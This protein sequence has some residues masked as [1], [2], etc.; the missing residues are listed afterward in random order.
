M[1]ST[2][3]GVNRFLLLVVGVLLLA[4][5]AA[6]IVLVAVP[7]IL[8]GWKQQADS[9]TGSAPDWVAAPAVGEVSVLTIVIGVVAVVL[10]LLLILFIVRHGQGH[11]SRVIDDRSS[12]TGRTLVDVG[13]P[14]SLLAAELDDRPEFVSSRISA[15]S[16]KGTPTLKV[17][18]QCR[19]GVSP[20][21]AARIVIDALHGMDEVLGTSLPAMVQVTGGFRSR[22]SS[23]ARLA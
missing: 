10:A 5:G 13:V 2:N 16:V 3:R 19:R 14:K 6:A 7:S 17:S 23:R 11:T 9:I 18:V 1:N 22:T 15:Y 20:A 12:D 4:L 8:Q 21:E